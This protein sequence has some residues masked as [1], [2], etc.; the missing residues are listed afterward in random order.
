V[1]GV[2]ARRPARGDVY[3]VALDPTLGPEIRGTRPCVVVP[4]NELNA[5]LNT[6]IVAPMTTGGARYPF[7]VPCRFQRQ[8]RHVVLDQVRV[9]DGVRLVKRLGAL[10]SPT[11]GQILAVLQEMFAPL[12]TGL[13]GA[14][15]STGAGS[16]GCGAPRRPVR[17]LWRSLDSLPAGQSPAAQ[18]PCH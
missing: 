18:P 7:R 3:L 16:P 1:D 12:P 10:D 17:A 5:H 6:F 9:V 4:P 14:W 13:M 11:L 2:A 8:T 15:S